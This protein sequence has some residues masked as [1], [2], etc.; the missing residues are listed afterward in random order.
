MAEDDLIPNARI[1]LSTKI[2]LSD[3]CKRCQSGDK[4]SE[5]NDPQVSEYFFNKYK[6]STQDWLSSKFY[7]I[8]Y[9]CPVCDKT[10]A[11]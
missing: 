1:Q 2:F 7:G 3:E 11:D 9:G 10:D 4:E 5:K 8:Q 6:T